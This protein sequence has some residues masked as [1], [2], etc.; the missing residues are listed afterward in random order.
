M[1]EGFTQSRKDAQ[2]NPQEHRTI[3]LTVFTSFFLRIFA[4]LREMVFRLLLSISAAAAFIWKKF[5][6]HDAP[7]YHFGARQALH[8]NLLLC[9]TE[10]NGKP[11]R[12]S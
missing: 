4:A 7:H 3:D 10:L 9:V 6:K 2:E 12:S 1:T 8:L 11:R 5:D